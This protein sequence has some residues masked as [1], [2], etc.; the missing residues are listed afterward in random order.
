MQPDNTTIAVSIWIALKHIFKQILVQSRLV[1]NE[2][3]LVL[4]VLQY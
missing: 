4:F 1:G 2:V 3:G